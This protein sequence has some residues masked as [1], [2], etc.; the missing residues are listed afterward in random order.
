MRLKR[1]WDDA[2][3]AILSR[4]NNS[5]M[6]ARNNHFNKLKDIASFIRPEDAINH[7]VISTYI[8]DFDGTIADTSI[9]SKL[10]PK[11][12]ATLSKNTGL[13]N[14]QIKEKAIKQY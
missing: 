9:Y 13:S 4:D 1:F 8:F 10:F 6:T 5:I 3:H 7:M 11:L 12:M 2:I 14:V